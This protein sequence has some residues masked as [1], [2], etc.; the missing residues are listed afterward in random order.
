MIKLIALDIDGTLLNSEHK[1]TPHT[2][3][4]IEKASAENI[5]IVLASGR[6]LE[7]MLPHLQTLNLTHAQ[8][9]ALCYNG[10]LV[11]SVGT[12]EIIEKLTLTGKDAKDL[13]AVSRDL[14]VFIHAFTQKQGLITPTLNPYTDHEAKINDLQITQLD[15]AELDDNDIVM[16][17]MMIDDPERLNNAIKHMPQGVTENYTIVKSAPIFLEF[18][19]V[20]ANKGNAIAA[21]ARHL[22][23][24]QSEVM[25]VGDA[26]N[27]HSMIQW[28][29]LGIAMGNA[30]FNTKNLANDITLTNDQDGVAEAILKFAL[31]RK[32]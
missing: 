10:G 2:K 19:N 29:G 21:L 31:N 26:E 27:D 17:V 32:K 9:Y 24:K 23:I 3:I 8:N 22:N 18:L 13:A 25:C 14:G 12:G 1:I 11:Q 4:V 30:D 16:K 6:P 20:N 7:G 5:Q 15:F 28:A